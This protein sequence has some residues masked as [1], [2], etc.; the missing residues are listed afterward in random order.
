MN[1]V[2]SNINTKISKQALD[3]GLGAVLGLDLVDPLD[4][5]TAVSNG[6]GNA[7]NIGFIKYQLI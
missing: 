1:W 5:N 3:S 6:T 7:G 4:S 2:K